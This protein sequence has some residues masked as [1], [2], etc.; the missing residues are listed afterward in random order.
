M[1]NLQNEADLMKQLELK[2]LKKEIEGII[3]EKINTSPSNSKNGQSDSSSVSS[4]II[5]KTEPT[6]N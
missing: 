5:L 1:I 4:K 3:S 6:K 2:Q